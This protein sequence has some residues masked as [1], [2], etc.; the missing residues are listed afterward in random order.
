MNLYD[1]I[2]NPIKNDE[3]LREL[4]EFY[5]TSENPKKNIYDK[6]VTSKDSKEFNEEK[7]KKDYEEL[8]VKPTIEELYKNIGT[9]IGLN[10][11]VFGNNSSIL[12]K[13]FKECPTYEEFREKLEKSFSETQK[14]V[15]K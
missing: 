1:S 5:K 12:E 6:L 11:D 3:I 2:K 8:I 4:I 14:N 13:V 15:L 10:E 9:R 7:Y